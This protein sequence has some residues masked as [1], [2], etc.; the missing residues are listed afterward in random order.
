MKMKAT[1]ASD[2]SKIEEWEIEN[3][4]DLLNKTAEHGDIVIHNPLDT[5]RPYQLTVYDDY[6][7]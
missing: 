4:Y 1:Y 3:L 6:M 2:R 5:W 7:D